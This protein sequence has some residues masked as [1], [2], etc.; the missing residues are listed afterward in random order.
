MLYRLF[1]HILIGP[2]LRVLGRPEVTGIESVPEDGPLIIAANHLAVVDSLYLALVL[3]RRVTFLAKLEYF[4]EP[5]IKGHAKR[6][7]CTALRQVPVDRTGGSAGS[8]ALAAATNILAR[9]EVWAIHPEGTRSPDGQVNRG[10]TGALRVAIAT[11]APLVPV[12]LTGTAVVN[13]PGSRR[14]YRGRVKIAFGP[15]RQYCSEVDPRAA[16]DA[17]MRELANGAGLKY[18]DHY[19]ATYDHDRP[20]PSAAPRLVTKTVIQ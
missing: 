6:W 11:G 18:V 1:K 13:P 12:S 3:S 16:T 9:G 20:R 10:R 5:G 14:W 17:L 8:D 15:P 4:T 2:L 19:A 7:F